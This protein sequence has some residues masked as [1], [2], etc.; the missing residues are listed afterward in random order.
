MKFMM[1]KKIQCIWKYV[2]NK[3]ICVRVL[4]KKKKKQMKTDKDTNKMT[5]NTENI[6]ESRRM[7]KNQQIF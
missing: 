6:K 7:R 1:Y 3:K 2:D 4:Y 5:E